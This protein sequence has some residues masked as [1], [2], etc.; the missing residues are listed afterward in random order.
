MNTKRLFQFMLAI[1]VVFYAFEFM[2][3]FW[4]LPILEHDKIFLPTHDRYIALYGLTY[5]SLLLL[6][7]WKPEKYRE[8]FII[9]MLGILAGMLNAS[10]IA[11]NGWYT[12]D[13]NAPSLDQNLSFIGR[14]S[15]VWY[16][17]TWIFWFRLR[18]R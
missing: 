11:A 14:A 7:A 18:S 5:A 4:G 8:L 16:I 3:H 15:V 17:A 2:I 9:I 12:K 1:G 13:F 6:T 10:Y